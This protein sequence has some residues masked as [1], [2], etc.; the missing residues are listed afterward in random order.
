MEKWVKS[1]VPVL[2]DKPRQKEEALPSSLELFQRV[3]CRRLTLHH[4]D[5]R[6][7]NKQ[8][9]PSGAFRRAEVV[10]GPTPEAENRQRQM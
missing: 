3:R 7:S 8:E 2:G 1:L 6:E 5:W 9:V 10:S 4:A